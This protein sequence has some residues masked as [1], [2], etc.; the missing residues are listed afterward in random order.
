MKLSAFLARGQYGW[1]A[2]M[3]SVAAR[4]TDA[5]LGDPMSR[6]SAG[7]ENDEAIS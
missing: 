1:E 2:R 4:Q 6:P 5:A 3:S 7:A